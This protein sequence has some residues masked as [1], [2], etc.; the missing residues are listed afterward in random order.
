MTGVSSYPRTSGEYV[1]PEVIRAL[2]EAGYI[3]ESDVQGYSEELR[4]APFSGRELIKDIVRVALKNRR[5][6]SGFLDKINTRLLQEANQNTSSGLGVTLYHHSGA[7]VLKGF[8]YEKISY[9]KRLDR[10]EYKGLRSEFDRLKR[11]SWLQDIAIHR[12][13]ELVS[14]GLSPKEVERMML[15]GKVPDGYQVH[16]RIP[17]DDGGDNSHDNFILIRDDVEH[18]ALHGYFN[19]AELRI[20]LLAHGETADVALPV[21]PKETIIYPNPQKGYEAEPVGYAAFLEMFDEH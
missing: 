21:P 13:Q 20:R 1:S 12:S 7:R 4:N 14:A 16:H 2:L 8:A 5:H 6:D 10:V 3:S 9:T 11:K 15:E 19:P 18:R 17:L